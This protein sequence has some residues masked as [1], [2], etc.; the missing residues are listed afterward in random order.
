[1]NKIG[2][3]LL[4]GMSLVCFGVHASEQEVAAQ[5]KSRDCVNMGPEAEHFASQLSAENKVMFCSQFTESQRAAAMQMVGQPDEAGNRMTADQ[6][7]QKV[8]LTT[9]TPSQE[10]TPTGCPVK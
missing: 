7:V 6:A 3:I 2:V 8:V 9:T 1:M 5:T 10:K 4:T